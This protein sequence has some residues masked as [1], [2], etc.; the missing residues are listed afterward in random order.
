MISAEISTGNAS[1]YC[2]VSFIVG[3]VSGTLTIYSIRK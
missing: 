3:I 1:C 2:S